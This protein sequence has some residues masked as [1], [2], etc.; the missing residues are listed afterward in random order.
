MSGASPLTRAGPG[1]P[2]SPCRSST[3]CRA[4]LPG[5][6]WA[7]SR[8]TSRCVLSRMTR[9]GR[10]GS[11]S[12]RPVAS[13]PPAR[14]P[15]VHPAAGTGARH[16]CAGVRRKRLPGTS[17]RR[18]ASQVTCV[19][20]GILAYGHGNRPPGDP[21]DPA[22]GRCRRRQPRQPA[23]GPGGHPPGAP[24]P[25]RRERRIPA[26]QGPVARRRLGG[27]DPQPTRLR[28]LLRASSG[29]ASRAGHSPAAGLPHLPRSAPARS[30][31]LPQSSA[32]PSGASCAPHWFPLALT[33]RTIRRAP[34]CGP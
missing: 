32:S 27:E 22:A 19:R 20:C 10:P 11:S 17:P 24:Q 18:L 13:L 9:R 1:T 14:Q 4:G 29:H 12:R 21:P 7:W 6:T 33:S 23:R 3:S 25:L 8:P 31:S 16:P 26:E 2:S 5:P 30:A 34:L 28:R 15:A